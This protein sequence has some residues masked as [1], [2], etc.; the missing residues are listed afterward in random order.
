[1]ESECTAHPRKEVLVLGP[2]HVRVMDNKAF[3]L[4]AWPYTLKRAKTRGAVAH[5]RDMW[6]DSTT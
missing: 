5:L 4:S 2:P 1:M 6:R 3:V